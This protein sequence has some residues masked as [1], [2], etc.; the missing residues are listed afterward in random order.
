[1]GPVE[2]IFIVLIIFFGAIGIVRGWQRELGVTTMLLL[3]LF[4]LTF[5]LPAN[6]QGRLGSLLGAVGF[7]DQQ[8]VVLAS[9]IAVVVLLGIAFISYQ[10]QT[11]VYPGTGKN[12]LLSLGIGLLN[13][14]L[15]AGSLWYYLGR[16]GW[17][18]VHVVPNYSNVYLFL[19]KILPPLIFGW[20]FFI[21]LA[22]AMLVLRVLK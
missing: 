18:L 13:G 10:G 12:S 22:I 14:Y 8:L 7:A 15:F 5:L 4:L 17:P 20:K 2:T 1:M 3:A 21:F 9:M 6:A 16:A 19:S 11:L